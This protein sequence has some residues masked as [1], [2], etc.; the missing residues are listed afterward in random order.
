MFELLIIIT[1]LIAFLLWKRKRNL[2]KKY[3]QFK[4]LTKDERYS[5]FNNYK[6]PKSVIKKFLK[7]NLQFKKTDIP[8]IESAL[9]D[10]FSIFLDQINCNY[11]TFPSIV[12]DE[13]WHSFILNKKEYRYFCMNS[14]GRII[15]HNKHNDTGDEKSSF[16]YRYNTFLY[17]NS[18]NRIESFKLDNKFNVKN[19]FNYEYMN[20][21][22]TINQNRNRNNLDDNMLLASLGMIYLNSNYDSSNHINN[23]DLTNL[24]GEIN[25]VSSSNSNNTLNTTPFSSGYDNSYSD[26]S[27]SSSCGSS[28]SSSSSSSCG[29]SGCGGS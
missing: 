5:F 1:I 10:Y 15:I 25:N 28:S 26:S 22:D 7:D 27:S 8:I 17:L 19:K 18:N 6:I 16:K 4:K 29:S 14:F 2:N 11:Y 20:H 24:N 12:A 9:M 23:V 3:T 21:I 13:L